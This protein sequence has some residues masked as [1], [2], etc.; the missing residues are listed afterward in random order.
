MSLCRT[1]YDTLQAVA[2]RSRLHYAPPLRH[3]EA[4]VQ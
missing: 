1:L 2:R 4:R 3:H